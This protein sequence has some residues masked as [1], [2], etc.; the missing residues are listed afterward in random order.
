MLDAF[1]TAG[2]SP[3]KRYRLKVATWTVLSASRAKRRYRA[4]CPRPR[5]SPTSSATSTSPRWMQ[6]WSGPRR[7]RPTAR[8]RAIAG[9]DLVGLAEALAVH[10]Q[11]HDDLLAVRPMI[12][13]VPALDSYWRTSRRLP[14]FDA[15]ERALSRTSHGDPSSVLPLDVAPT[16]GT[17]QEPARKNGGSRRYGGSR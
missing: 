3:P 6:C 9:E 14:G 16:R 10:D 7:S 11:A 15:F 12:A 13:R 2:S 5:Q 8:T 1:K 4:G 17:G